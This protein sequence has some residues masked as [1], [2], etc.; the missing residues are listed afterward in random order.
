MKYVQL[1]TVEL[2]FDLYSLVQCVSQDES[3]DLSN[4]YVFLPSSMDIFNADIDLEHLIQLDTVWG[5][6]SI[7]VMVLLRDL[8]PG[9]LI[10][11]VSSGDYRQR[12]R[13]LLD[14]VG[15]L[16]IDDRSFVRYVARMR[17]L[18]EGL[19][20]PD[21]LQAAQYYPF[22][23]WPMSPTYP[24]TGAWSTDHPT[25]PEVLELVMWCSKLAS[26]YE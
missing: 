14:A 4:V 16:S 8:P 20:L 26:P 21:T 18:Q 17:Q 13:H 23:L 10:P 1:D 12:A 22:S 9:H 15:S 2:Y 5:D 6:Y 19:S 11:L 24:G 25:T 7:E 3:I